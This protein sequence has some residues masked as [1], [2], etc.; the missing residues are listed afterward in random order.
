MTRELRLPSGVLTLVSAEDFSRV[1]ALAWFARREGRSI[2]VMHSPGVKATKVRLHRFVMGA[3]RGDIVDHINGDTLDNRRDNLRFVTPRQSAQN[4]GPHA[5]SLSSFVGVTL[6]RAT[7]RWQAQICSGGVCRYLGL[8]ND[9]REAALA[10]DAAA[11]ETYGEF[12]R[13]NFPEGSLT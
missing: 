11:H 9:E 6:H 12:A 8:F 13:L 10:Y 1:S 4:R 5:G 2:Y 7:G 3:R